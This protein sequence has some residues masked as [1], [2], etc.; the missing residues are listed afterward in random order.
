MLSHNAYLPKEPPLIHRTAK[1]PAATVPDDK[2]DAE[3]VA[4]H[5]VK[6][7]IDGKSECESVPRR[8]RRRR[9]RGKEEKDDDDGGNG[10]DGEPVDD[11]KGRK[12]A[13]KGNGNNW[14]VTRRVSKHGVW[15]LIGRQ[16]RF[17]NDVKARERYMNV[18]NPDI[19]IDS[20]WTP[21]ED[22]DLLNYHE[23]LGDK[24][25]LI[26][27]KLGTNR[28]DCYCRQRVKQLRKRTHGIRSKETVSKNTTPPTNT[29][30]DGA[31]DNHSNALNT[32]M[33]KPKPKRRGRG[34]RKRDGEDTAPKTPRKRPRRSMRRAAAT[35]RAQGIERSNN[36]QSMPSAVQ[37]PVSK[38]RRPP[39]ASLCGAPTAALRPIPALEPR[40]QPLSTMNVQ[41]VML[42]EIG[43]YSNC[44]ALTLPALDKRTVSGISGNPGTVSLHSP[45][46]TSESA[47]FGANNGMQR[48]PEND[49]IP[50][51]LSVHSVGYRAACDVMQ[52]ETADQFISNLPMIAA[53]P[54]MNGSKG[55]PINVLAN[56]VPPGDALQCPHGTGTLT[57]P[58][59]TERIPFDDIPAFTMDSA[60]PNV[61]M[62]LTANSHQQKVD[63][64]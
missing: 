40:P 2:A 21:Q 35:E 12:G 32:K 29:A 22:A 42:P 18:L 24:W 53:M 47:A 20:S 45:E 58:P 44:N 26:A 5:E 39:M 57:A 61:P 7:D 11:R 10:S 9:R 4:E 19:D 55:H 46:M 13:Q 54:T 8:R 48:Y 23:E 59:Q 51:P 62:S 14:S 30:H 3:P 64:S 56:G 36:A 52:N 37:Q 33:Q 1:V 28:T 38:S 27:R 50:Q 16:I 34:K 49:V 60:V 41:R 17:R 6:Q 15:V 25:A 63:V 31:D 43:R